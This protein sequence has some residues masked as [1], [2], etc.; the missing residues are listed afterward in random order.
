MSNKAILYRMVTDEHICPYG[1]RSK[2][3]LERKGYD[4][5]DHHLTSRDETDKFKA[6]HGV[7]TTPQ[8]FINGKRIGGYDDLRE[9]FNKGQ[10]GQTGTT[11]TPVIA[12]FSVAALLALAFQYYVAG[13]IV[14]IRTLMLFIAFS[15]T[16]LAVQKLKDLYSFTNSFI[17]YD[18]LA[19]RWLRY[20][21][22]YPFVEAYA[23]I[24]MVAQLPALA[25][26]PFSLFIG[27][28]GA[29]SVFKAVYIDKREL[30]C[31]CVG[32]DSNVPLGF[33]SLSENLFMIA[34]A[35]I[36]LFR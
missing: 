14:S 18:L 13:D 17:T 35:L 10:A 24:G 30:K 21:Y 16:L 9:F 6:E 15:M 2:D 32:G 7:E 12:I 26:A 20:G 27:T 11:Y 29:I 3:L 28:V 23:G 36:M 19:M 34:G 31:A 4:V 33:V 22:I 25:V 1:L 5:E 8:T